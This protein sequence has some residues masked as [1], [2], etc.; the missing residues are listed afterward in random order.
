MT[1]SIQDLERDIEET[2][3]RLDLTIDQLQSRMSVSGVVDDMMGQV[4]QSRYSQVIDHTLSA[5]RRNPV[6]VLLV[7][8]GIGLLATRMSQETAAARR[9]ARTRAYYAGDYDRGLE[10]ERS[11]LRT[12]ADRG[13]DPDAMPTA[14]TADILEPRSAG[15]YDARA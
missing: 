13:Y 11:A 10:V 7:I 15:A 14:T 2:R 4:R 9:R 3:A 6:P 5:I 12:R 8:A 1:E